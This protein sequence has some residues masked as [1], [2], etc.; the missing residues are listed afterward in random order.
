MYQSGPL[1][2]SKSDSTY[3][4]DNYFNHYIVC[5]HSHYFDCHLQKYSPRSTIK[6]HFYAICII[7]FDE[8]CDL[9]N[10]RIQNVH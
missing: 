7:A 5:H 9:H 2:A 6:Q 3:G 1:S 4:R 8:F 10:H